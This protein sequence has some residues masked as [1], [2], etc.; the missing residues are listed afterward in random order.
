MIPGIY[1]ITAYRNDTLQKTVSV[2]DSTGSPVSFATATMKMQVRTKPDGDVLLELTEGDGLTVG[3]AGNNVITI[4][5]VVAI[6]GCGA[7]Y[8]DIQATFSS[9]VV[10]TY[11]KGAFIV[12]KDITL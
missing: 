11:L 1:N 5:K 12:Q 8:Y 10:S 4:S 3:G 7:Y 6:Q 2:V 9:G